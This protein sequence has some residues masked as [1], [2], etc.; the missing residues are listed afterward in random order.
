VKGRAA[1]LGVVA[2]GAGLSAGCK[3]GK[4]ESKA[5]IP[6]VQ[7]RPKILSFKGPHTVSCR[8]KGQSVTVAFT[9]ETK[10][11]A[12]VDPEIDGHP[13]GAQAGY[14][15]RRGTMRFPYPCPGP[16]RL[17]IAAFNR[18]GTAARQ[19]ARVVSR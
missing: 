7:L 15:P 5:T 3:G 12:S 18:R 10:N 14:P 8:Q 11:A 6:V 9:Y 13:V 4:H 2:L 16:H 1:L 17:T 19:T